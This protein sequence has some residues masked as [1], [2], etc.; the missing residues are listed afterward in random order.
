MSGAGG[1]DTTDRGAERV[2]S[3]PSTVCVA[4]SCCPA[5]SAAIV[6]VKVPSLPT[7]PVP[8]PTLSTKIRTRA[9]GA[10]APMTLVAPATS[11]G[12]SAGAGGIACTVTG[13]ESALTRSTAR[14]V[15]RTTPPACN[16]GTST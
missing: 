2:L 6:T 11:G 5:T 16:G 9:A 7:T 3:T 12:I 8:A 13:A 1:T 4:W 14:W 15:A 10:P